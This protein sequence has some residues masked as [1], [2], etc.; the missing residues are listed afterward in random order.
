MG[1]ANIC[2]SVNVTCRSAR[3]NI[4]FD[5]V[6]LVYTLM[7][8]LYVLYVA[9]PCSLPALSLWLPWRAVWAYRLLNKTHNGHNELTLRRRS[10]PASQFECWIL[11]LLIIPICPTFFLIRQIHFAILFSFINEPH[12]PLVYYAWLEQC[13]HFSN[14]SNMKLIKW[15]GFNR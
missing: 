6:S 4:Y 10:P 5:S 15:N 7:Y 1:K 8:R 12:S 2:V 13:C 9:S 14:K 3:L 11:S